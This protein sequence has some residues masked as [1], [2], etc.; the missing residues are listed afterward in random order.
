MKPKVTRRELASAVLAS[1]VLMAQTPALPANP[2]EEVKS[3]RERNHLTGAQLDKF[4]LPMQT[5]PAVHF[6][7]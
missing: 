5:E 4:E 2:E 7:A 3:A 1:G 6:K